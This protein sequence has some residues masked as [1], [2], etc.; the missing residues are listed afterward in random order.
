MVSALLRTPASFSEVCSNHLAVAA[1][2]PALVNAE[3]LHAFAAAIVSLVSN[4]I[5][6]VSTA[7]RLIVRLGRVRWRRSFLLGQNW[8]FGPRW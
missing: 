3:A 8:C 5:A 6:L 4:T 1:L 2:Q 7:I